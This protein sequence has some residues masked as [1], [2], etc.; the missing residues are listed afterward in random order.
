MVNTKPTILE[1]S[2]S[3]KE[4][5]I[6]SL[7]AIISFI[8]G[9]IIIC[10]VLILNPK[11]TM[12]QFAAIFV[13]AIMIFISSWRI[14]RIA[15]MKL[16]INPEE[17]RYRD[18]FVWNKISWSEVISIGQANDIETSDHKSVLRKI[19]SLIFLTDDG[20]KRFDM[21]AYTLAHGLEII[22]TVIDSK[23][24]LEEKESDSED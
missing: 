10:G 20:V 18:R 7:I 17:I 6:Y 13:G 2:P 14:L 3:L 21:S 15:T 8:F 5:L 12:A 4:R 9:V 23:P 24:K 11:S 19:K 16:Y 22:N 1:L